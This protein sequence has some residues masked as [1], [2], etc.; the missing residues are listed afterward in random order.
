MS[1]IHI[2]GHVSQGLHARSV[3][4]LG[5]LESRLPSIVILWLVLAA[6]ASAARIVR[7]PLT[8]S[9]DVHSVLPYVLVVLAPAASL[10]LALRWFDRGHLLPQPHT[11]LALA[12]R[13]RAVG[14]AEAARHPLY[15][16]TGIMVSLLIGMLLN[17]PVRAAEYFATMPAISAEVPEWLSVLHLLM[18]A[19]VVILSSLYVICFVA[20]LRRVPLFPLMLVAVWSIDL[21]MLLVIAQGAASAGLPEPVGSSLNALLNGNIKKVLIS[22]GLWLPYLMLSTRVNVTYRHRVPA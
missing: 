11:R 5:S 6:L 10:V 18:T 13:W 20:A 17:A 15:G 19:D 7:S 8:P 1:P 22:V 14:L 16:T 2:L 12:G 9:I 4:V 21:A 3:T